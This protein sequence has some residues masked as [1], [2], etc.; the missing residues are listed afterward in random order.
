MNNIDLV[1]YL[2]SAKMELFLIIVISILI[3][4]YYLLK[5]LVKKENKN[6]KLNIRQI[7]DYTSSKYSKR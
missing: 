2:N 5:K 6:L 7:N 4:I 3:F 1:Q